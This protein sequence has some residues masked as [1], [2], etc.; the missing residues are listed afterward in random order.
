MFEFSVCLLYKDEDGDSRN[1]VPRDARGSLPEYSPPNP[2]PNPKTL[3]LTLTLT[4]TPNPN[5]NPN[6]NA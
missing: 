4:L 2:N 1:P 3:A 6:P 5:P